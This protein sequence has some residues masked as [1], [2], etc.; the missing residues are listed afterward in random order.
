MP[1]G[2]ASSW[3]YGNGVTDTRTFDLDYRMTGVKDAGTSNIQYLSYSYN[4]ANRVT[5]IT[6]HVTAADNQT[7]AYD[8]TGQITFASGVYGT[9]TISYNSNSSR[10]DRRRPRLHRSACQQPDQKAWHDEH[11]LHVK[12]QYHEHRRGY[13]PLQQGQPDGPQ[14]FPGVRAAATTTPSGSA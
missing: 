11:P 5:A 9:G 10:L 7:F 12:R 1:F 3:T 6:D 8:R 2:P 4:A 13:R 14:R